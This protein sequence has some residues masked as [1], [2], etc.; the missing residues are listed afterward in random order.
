MEVFLD[1]INIVLRFLQD[2]TF[3]I[4]FYELLICFTILQK[5][6]MVA[7][8]CLVFI[9]YIVLTNNAIGIVDYIN[10][11][12]VWGDLHFGYVLYFAVSL[13]LVW[14]CFEEKFSKILFFCTTAY[15]IE[16]FGSQLGNI[17]NLMFFGGT[18]YVEIYNTPRPLLYSIVR[19][20]LEVPIIIFTYL[21]IK[22]Y[23]HNYEF[24]LK[25][26]S[27]ILIE[28]VTLTI[29]IFLN[30][31][32]T[33]E[34][35]M[36]VVARIYAAIGCVFILCFQFAFLNENGLKHENK[37]I[38]HLLEVQGNQYELSKDNIE[39]LNIN[40]HDLKR[41]ISALRLVDGK[42]EREKVLTELENTASLYETKLD[43]GNKALDVVLMEKT[44]KCRDKKIQFSCVADG[45][46]LNFMSPFDIYVLFSNAIDNLIESL[47][48]V[49]AEK[50]NASLCIQNKDDGVFVILENYCAEPPQFLDG[51]PITTKKNKTVHG[52]GVKSIRAVVE[53]YGGYYKMSFNDKVFTLKIV[54]I[55]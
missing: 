13:L 17:L 50:R 36:N 2:T 49:A 39:R 3:V 52:Y 31:Y 51:L 44:L 26:S 53:K 11:Y 8:R 24:R 30:Y 43:T 5:R 48:P 40:C 23:K 42:D 20:F 15:I 46:A 10:A 37:L 55:A 27:I 12:L 21:Y 33:M 18:E 54:F 35:Y 28:I 1:G 14:F 45:A 47:T 4:V 41:L 34:N 16:N 6:K 22:K 19:Q 25:N 7:F 9:P 32:G 29:I 38:S